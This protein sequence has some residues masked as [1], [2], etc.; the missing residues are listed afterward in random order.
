MRM[1]REVLDPVK[2]AH[3]MHVHKQKTPQKVAD[4]EGINKRKKEGMMKELQEMTD[5]AEKRCEEEIPLTKPLQLNV[6]K[7]KKKGIKHDRIGSRE[8]YYFDD[9]DEEM[10]D[11]PN[12]PMQLSTLIGS[13]SEVFVKSATTK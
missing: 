13:P 1:H 4:M 10:V 7:R 8:L 11:T 3:K 9:D 5:Y 6:P 12:V 2:Y